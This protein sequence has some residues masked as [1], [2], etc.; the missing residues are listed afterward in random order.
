M[1]EGREKERR[2]ENKRGMARDVDVMQGSIS[3]GRRA[4]SAP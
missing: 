4:K 2:K 3:P 1:V